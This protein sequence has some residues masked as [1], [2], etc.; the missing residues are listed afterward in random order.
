MVVAVDRVSVTEELKQKLL[1]LLR[2]GVSVK[3]ALGEVKRSRS[4]YEEQRRRDRAWSGLVDAVRLGVG[5]LRASDA[6]VGEFAE[7]CVNFLGSGVW[8]HQQHMID[9]LEGR[10]PSGLHS[11]M[12]F[13][14][15]SAGLSRLLVNV[16]PNHAK[17]MT[18]TINY[19]TYRICKD[20]NISVIIVSKTQEQAKKYL[21]AIKQRLSHPKYA[22]LQVA[23]GPVDGFKGTA[24][25]WSANKIYLGGD[26][27]DSGEKDPTV[28][29]LGIG[30]QIY[31]ARAK[32]IVLDDVVTLA[33]AGEWPKQMDWIRQ[34]VAS[35]LG[36]D[37]QLLVVGTRVASQDLYRALRDPDHYADG[38]V[39]WT[40]LGMPAVLE[41]GADAADWLT[42]WPVSD[43]PFTDK[44]QPLPDGSFPRWTGERLARVRNEVGAVK[45]SMVYQQQDVEENSTFDPVAVRGSMDAMRKP[46]PLRSGA[47]GHPAN[48]E[49][50]Y[51]ICS[52]DPAIA[53]DMAVCAYAVD[54]E[55][56]KRYVM[57]M[58]VITSPKPSQIRDIFHQWTDIHNPNEWI[59]EDNAFQGFL[60]QDEEIRK[61]LASRGVVMRSHHTGSNKMDPDFGV[62]SMASLFG[63]VQSRDDGRGVKFNKDNLISLPDMGASFGIKMLVEQLSVWSPLVK[64]KHRKQDTVMALWFAEIR[65]REVMNV[66]QGRQSWFGSSGFVSPR[67]EESRMVIA[68][69]DWAAMNQVQYL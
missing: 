43:V 22:D 20:P 35:R 33:N 67:D 44:D 36:P 32:L 49:G 56:G 52:M 38:E 68:L 2:S 6:Q 41:G 63:S 4:W 7:F 55:T 30:G 60:A 10:E 5:E 14:P 62:A 28:E 18:I 21:Y 45:W 23:F 34:E 58:L 31:G 29:A 69:D 66:S 64:T 42:L 13:E 47:A 3:D 9:L 65:A 25:Q 46:G 26:A 15:G 50:F 51:R 39:P 11:S 17:S 16:P 19:V 37:G 40:Y 57:D 61:F 54:R 1:L 53:G 48:A 27:K 24:D 8:P 12:L 59:V